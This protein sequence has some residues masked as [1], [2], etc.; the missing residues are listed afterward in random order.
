MQVE[1]STLC[2]SPLPSSRKLAL[3][4]KVYKHEEIPV[5][6]QDSFHHQH[7]PRSQRKA[8]FFNKASLLTRFLLTS[9]CPKETSGTP[10]TSPSAMHLQ[11]Y[12]ASFLAIG[13]V[14]AAATPEFPDQDLDIRSFD[15]VEDF[16]PRAFDE[17]EDLDIRDFDEDEHLEARDLVDAVDVEIRDAEDGFD[18]FARA[19]PKC[20]SGLVYSSKYRKCVCKKSGYS[21]SKKSKKCYLNCGSSAYNKQG[22]GKCVCKKSGYTFSSKDRKCHLNCGTSAYNKQGKGKCVCK[23]SGYTFSSSTK[24]CYLKCPSGASAKN[25]K[26]VCSNSSKEL[27]NGSCVCKSGKV[28]DGKGG[29]RNECPSGTSYSSGACRCPS[30]DLELKGGSCQCKVSGATRNGNSCECRADEKVENNQ[31]VDKC[32]SY[33][34]FNT[35]KDD[36]VCEDLGKKFDPLGSTKD[37][38]CKCPSGLEFKST[39]K[40]PGGACVKDCLIALQVFDIEAGACVCIGGKTL[41]TLFPGGPELC[42]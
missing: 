2:A 1:I 40:Y 21:Y 18:L 38:I 4:F 30:S 19:S 12:F 22:K 24:K 9:P 20:P 35:S 27:K 23:T 10:T 3:S 13:T 37:E 16:D 39:T 14:L 25:G 36:C 7:T 17:T 26:C 33:A 28:S 6:C 29:C 31:C 41:K 11:H 32:P 8:S 5:E 15:D 42:L 34:P